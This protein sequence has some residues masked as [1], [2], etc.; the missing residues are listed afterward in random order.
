MIPPRGTVLIM[1]TACLCSCGGSQI[2]VATM[3]GMVVLDGNRKKPVD[4]Y[5]STLLL[6]FSGKRTVGGASALEWFAQVLFDTGG[7]QVSRVFLA[8]H[9][10]I[11]DALGIER[12]RRRYSFSE[13]LPGVAALTRAAHA[14]ESKPADERNPFEMEIVRLYRNVFAYTRIAGS[15]GFLDPHPTLAVDD[16]LARTRLGF[17]QRHAASY[18]HLLTKTDMLSE[19]MGTLRADS[20]ASWTPSESAFVHLSMSM[21]RLQSGM[22]NPPPHIIPE[23]SPSNRKGGPREEQ[24][25]S[26]WGY[27]VAHGS[28]AR[29]NEALVEL[30][31][32]RRAYREDNQEAFDGAVRAFMR[33]VRATKGIEVPSTTLEVRYNRLSP[34][35][36]ARVCFA[37]TLL[38]ALVFLFRP[39]SGIRGA[40]LVLCCLGIVLLSAGMIMRMAIMHRPPV[41]NLYE[42]FVFVAWACALLGLVLELM[43]RNGIGL[44]VAAGGGFAFVHVAGRY[45]LEG[46]TMGMLAAVLNNNFWLASHIMTISLG[47][48]G[49]TAA[50]VVG[51]V[52]L[53]KRCLGHD[54]AAGRGVDGAMRGM[55]LFGLTFTVVGTVLGGLWADQAWGRFW[56]WDPKENG[57]MLIILWSSAVVHARSGG[58]IRGIGTAMGSVFLFVLVMFA[59]LGV[60]LLGIGMH[61]YG[62]TSRG[63]R[64]L[65]TVV[66][67]EML[68]LIVAG[69]VS[70]IRGSRTAVFRVHN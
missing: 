41:T 39:A 22:G 15:L 6:R 12:R 46:D 31:A 14:A 56:G 40:G 18:W 25:Y 16:S 27:A 65:F 69:T 51:H 7:A 63:A 13:L 64:L 66:G 55:L 52:Y 53:V 1:L 23:V 50:A 70:G 26:P 60:N 35:G 59:W 11:P 45:G 2:D 10:G 44:I 43:Q 62:F 4:T 61:A 58:L 49:C 42:T 38:A 68:F 8:D 9:P 17:G 48:A 67:A 36:R 57:A 3:A 34:V 21:Y 37:L 29:N 24:W 54:E 32:M 30:V 28:A 5:A 20:A 19:T 33:V 47:Y